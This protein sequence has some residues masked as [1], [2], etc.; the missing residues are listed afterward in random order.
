VL[1]SPV[2]TRRSATLGPSRG[3]TAFK[4]EDEDEFEDED[5]SHPA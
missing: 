2:G 1:A 3:V 4:I 5:E